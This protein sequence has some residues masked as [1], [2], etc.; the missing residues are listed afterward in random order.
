MD[1]LFSCSTFQ[2][3][4]AIPVVAFNSFYFNRITELVI[5]YVKFDTFTPAAERG[6]PVTRVISRMTLQQILARAVGSDIIFNES[7][8]MDFV[9]DGEKVFFFL[10][11]LSG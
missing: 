2:K 6:L 9:D 4:L 7:N 1:W 5:R 10:E 11:A 8:V 3:V